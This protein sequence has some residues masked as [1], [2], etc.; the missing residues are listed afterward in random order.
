MQ[1]KKFPTV[2]IQY[3]FFL[4]TCIHLFHLIAKLHKV[5]EN[6]LQCLMLK[7]IIFSHTVDVNGTETFYIISLNTHI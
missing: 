4:H 1:K 6:K 7:K 5:Y 2:C 3:I